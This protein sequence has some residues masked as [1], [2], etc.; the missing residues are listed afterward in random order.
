MRE[1]FVTPNLDEFVKAWVGIF[2]HN[3]K[4]QRLWREK[5]GRSMATYSETQWWSHW[6]VLKQSMLYFGD[7]EPLLHENEVSPAYRTEVI[8]ILNDPQKKYC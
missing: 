3:R 2:S 1:K 5:T 7:I 8:D 6:E 4:A